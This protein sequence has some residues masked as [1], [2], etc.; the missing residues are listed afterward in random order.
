MK[1]YLLTGFATLLPIALTLMIII[2]LIDFFTTPFVGIVE[3]FLRSY[4]ESHGLSFLHHD[5]IVIIISRLIILAFLFFF[6][7]LLGFFGRKITLRFTS[8][9]FARIP[10]INSVY[11]ISKDV[12]KAVFSQKEKTFKETVLVPFPK[13][14]THALGLVTGEI[15]PILKEKIQSADLAVFVPTAPHPLS[16]YILMTPRKEALPVDLTTEEVFKFLLSCG[17][18]YTKELKDEE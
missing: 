5:T 3:Y 9:L 8:M 13:E 7:L 14:N 2:W 11:R 6:T 4:E 10:F 16:G 15:P 17:V 18:T 1:K 12:T